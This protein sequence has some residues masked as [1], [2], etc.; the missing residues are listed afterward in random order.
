[1]LSFLLKIH[2]LNVVIMIFNKLL[3]REDHNLMGRQM[4][5]NLHWEIELEPLTPLESESLAEAQQ[6]VR[7]ELLF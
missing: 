5:K 4:M 1:M 2:L 3:I 6:I 7:E